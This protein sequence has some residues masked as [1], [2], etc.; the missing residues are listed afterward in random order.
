MKISHL[1]KE[2]ISSNAGVENIIVTR[3]KRSESGG[4]KAASAA[5]YRHGWREN[6]DRNGV[7]LAAL[8][9]SSEENGGV[10]HQRKVARK[11]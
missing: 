6:N 8:A 10:D 2:E 11:S 1:L 7:T 3:R 5:K 4:G 9:I